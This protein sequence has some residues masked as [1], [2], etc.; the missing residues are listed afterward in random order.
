MLRRRIA[1]WFEKLSAGCLVA[2]FIQG[3]WQGV[4]VGLSFFGVCLYLTWR[5]DK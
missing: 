5:A 1:D 3:Y 4:V 2:S